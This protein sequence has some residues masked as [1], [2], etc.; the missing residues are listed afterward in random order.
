MSSIVHTLFII[1]FENVHLEYMT[2]YHQLCV[3]WDW[4]EG[5]IGCL[6]MADCLSCCW[7]L[8]SMDFGTCQRYGVEVRACGST[9][10]TSVA[11]HPLRVSC[12]SARSDR[13]SPARHPSGMHTGRTAQRPRPSCR[14]FTDLRHKGAPA[15]QANDLPPDHAHAAVFGS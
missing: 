9:G 11:L 4:L 15:D 10:V 13:K 8:G 12:M 1:N 7:H 3:L 6:A 5:M 2:M 14:R